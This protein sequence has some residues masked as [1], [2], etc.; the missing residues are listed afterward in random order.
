[1]LNYAEFTEWKPDA[2][3]FQDTTAGFNFFSICYSISEACFAT[4]LFCFDACLDS[5]QA[6]LTLQWTMQGCVVFPVRQMF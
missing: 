5:D 2:F 3:T 4:R 6:C 1:M